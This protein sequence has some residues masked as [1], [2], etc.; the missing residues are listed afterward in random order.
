VVRREYI[1]APRRPRA[2]G[3]V[4]VP[5]IGTQECVRLLLSEGGPLEKQ[6]TSTATSRAASPDAYLRNGGPREVLC[7]ERR[8][9]HL[10]PSHILGGRDDYFGEA[11]HPSGPTTQCLTRYNQCPMPSHVRVRAAL[12]SKSRVRTDER[13]HTK[14]DKPDEHAKVNSRAAFRRESAPPR[15]RDRHQ[16]VGSRSTSGRVA[17]TQSDRNKIPPDGSNRDQLNS[18]KIIGRCAHVY[19]GIKFMGAFLSQFLPARRRY[20]LLVHSNR[21]T[22][23]DIAAVEKKTSSG[24]PN[25]P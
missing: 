15:D 25:G 23:V 8:Y 5:T 13:N 16:V 9:C 21:G 3:L 2:R 24:R 22:V 10:G 12:S 19:T 17:R 6:K 7:T 20:K 18:R 4:Q 11:T 14:I 1:A